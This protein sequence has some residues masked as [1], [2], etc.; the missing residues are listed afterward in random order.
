MVSRGLLSPDDVS[1]AFIDLDDDSGEASLKPI[2]VNSNGSLK[3]WPA[4]VF[5]ES[6]DLLNDILG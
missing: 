5:S 6:Y 4:G 2:D 1:I 3:W